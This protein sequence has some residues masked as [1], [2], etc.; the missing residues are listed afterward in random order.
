MEYQNNLQESDNITLQNQIKA[1]RSFFAKWLTGSLNLWNEF[2]IK[3][4]KNNNWI[5]IYKIWNWS[6]GEKIIDSIK[7]KKLNWSFLLNAKFSPSKTI[8]IALYILNI[9]PNSKVI[10]FFWE[11]KYDSK[12][13]KIEEY[14]WFWNIILNIYKNF[15]KMGKLRSFSNFRKFNIKKD[16]DINSIY[17]EDF[18]NKNKILKYFEKNNSEWAKIALK[19]VTS[20]INDNV[21]LQNQLSSYIYKTWLFD[22]SIIYSK[23]DLYILYDNLTSSQKSKIDIILRQAEIIFQRPV[24]SKSTLNFLV[25]HK[26]NIPEIAKWK[27]FT[28]IYCDFDGTLFEDTLPWTPESQNPKIN[29]NILDYLLKKQK[30]WSKITIMTWWDLDQ[31]KQIL[32][33]NWVDFPIIHKTKLAWWIIENVIDNISNSKVFHTITKILAVNY[34]HVD[35]IN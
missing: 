16:W 33:D 34:I 3:E 9:F 29:Y 8:D 24:N 23:S 22:P 30:Q 15:S 25:R 19:F 21:N 35:E 14:F 31:R 20:K 10:I 32:L 4:I 5:S 2:L 6:D 11:L 18:N 28:W 7:N 12:V 26:K 1:L 13:D 17:D 27:Y